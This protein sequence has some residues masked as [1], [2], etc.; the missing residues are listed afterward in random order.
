MIWTWGSLFVPFE[1]Y[2]TMRRRPKLQVKPNVAPKAASRGPDTS[3]QDVDKKAADVEPKSEPK[4]T[5]TETPAKANAADRAEDIIEKDVKPNEEKVETKPSVAEGKA[6]LT[7]KPASSAGTSRR[8]RIRPQV[9]IRG[10]GPAS[11]NTPVDAKTEPSETLNSSVDQSFPLCETSDK[12]EQAKFPDS[13]DLVPKVLKIAK[14]ACVNKANPVRDQRSKQIVDGGDN[15]P[16]NA[17]I[18]TET[19]APKSPV[20]DPQQAALRRSR[21]LRARPN[22]TEA[23]RARLR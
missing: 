21:F 12:P 8:S 18:K 1:C 2:S 11:T 22:L 4:D 16:T 17:E 5:F 7:P 13:S 23:G 3:S 6:T 15:L 14:P 20:K 10:R 19:A 9:Q